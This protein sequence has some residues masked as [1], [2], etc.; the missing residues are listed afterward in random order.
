VAEETEAVSA[1]IVTAVT[2]RIRLLPSDHHMNLSEMFTDDQIA[3]LSCLGAL[4]VCGLIAAVSYHLGPAGRT[5]R[6]QR[7]EA[8]QLQAKSPVSVGEREQRRAA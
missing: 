4:T 3:I 7:R 5:Q 2:L 1:G 6:Q 8:L